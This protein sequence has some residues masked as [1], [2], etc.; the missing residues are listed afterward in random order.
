MVVVGE[1]AVVAVGAV[2]GVVDTR[3]VLVGVVAVLFELFPGK[4]MAKK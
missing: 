3:G 1:M 4:A 2:V